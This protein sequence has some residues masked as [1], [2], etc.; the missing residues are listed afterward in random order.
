VEEVAIKG[1]A[2]LDLVSCLGTVLV[3]YLFL[4]ERLVLDMKAVDVGVTNL[5][6]R[7]FASDF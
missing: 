3:S 2:A 7:A 5:V 6:G 1:Y 4:L